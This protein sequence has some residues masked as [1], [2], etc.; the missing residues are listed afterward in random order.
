MRDFK[1]VYQHF[2]QEKV[3]FTPVYQFIK[4]YDG[5]NYRKEVDNCLGGGRYCCF[6]PDGPGTATGREIGME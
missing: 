2:D 6:D 4:G 1:E 5:D 3:T